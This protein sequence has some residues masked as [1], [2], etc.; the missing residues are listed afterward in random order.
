MVCFP[1]HVEYW[2]VPSQYNGDFHM[3]YIKDDQPSYAYQT[4]HDY[5]EHG[6]LI[7]DDIS[8]TKNI[9]SIC[10]DEVKIQKWIESHKDH[11]YVP[12]SDK[13]ED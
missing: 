1:E 8:G 2:R 6:N 11:M 13:S 9:C 12:E 7:A 3:I 4:G 5:C 10:D